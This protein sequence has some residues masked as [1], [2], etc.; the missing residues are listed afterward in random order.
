MSSEFLNLESETEEQLRK[1]VEDYTK[2]LYAMSP[3]S[4][5]YDQVQEMISAIMYELDERLEIERFKAFAPEDG[6]LDIGIIDS[7]VIEQDMDTDEIFKAV[8]TSYTSKPK[9]NKK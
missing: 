9:L 4:P 1:R 2:K 3:E 5:M 8:V 7:E 6:A